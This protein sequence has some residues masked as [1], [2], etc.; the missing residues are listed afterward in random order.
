[1]MKV[2][3][4]GYELEILA[5]I[6]RPQPCIDYLCGDASLAH[7]DAGSLKAA[8]SRIAD[9]SFWRNRNTPT[10]ITT[11]GRVPY[12][13]SVVVPVYNVERYLARCVDSLISQTLPDMQIILVNDGSKDR[14]GEMI[15][16][17]ARRHPR[18]LCIDKANGGCALAR[19]AGLSA[20]T[21]EYVG[22][23]DSD[24]W[25]DCSMFKKLHDKAVECDADVVQGGL[26]KY[27]EQANRFDP[28]NED[29]LASLV[30][31]AG[32]QM[33]HARDL[34]CVQPTMWRRIYRRTMLQQNDITF[35]QHVRMFDDLP[36]Q[37]M[38][39]GLLSEDC[40]RQ[41]AALLLPPPAARAGRRG[42]GRA[43]VRDVP[44][45]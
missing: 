12:S 40:H 14:S 43:I 20:A 25:V 16:D 24:D 32:N 8:S 36:F 26:V 2:S 18:I 22:F 33:E 28:V 44:T 1:M 21:G 17:Y 11:E 13:V 27:Y 3:S 42:Y 15:K 37:F 23:V 6:S 10:V 29:A 38:A 45:L 9:R 41:R 4:E 31:R 5:S 7:G 39:H 19:N 30:E 34:L 35:P